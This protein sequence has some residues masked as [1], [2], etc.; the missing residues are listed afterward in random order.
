M[1]RLIGVVA[2]LVGA[3]A[4]VLGVGLAIVFGPDDRV[5]S[6]PHPLRS[7][8]VAVVTGPSTI[9]YYGL[10]VRVG[11]RAARPGT[12]IFLALAHS[13]DV[14]DY[15][16]R[17]SYTRIDSVRLPWKVSTSQ[18]HGSRAPEAPP[19][20]LDIWLDR[21]SGQPTA[22]ITMPLPDAAVALVVMNADGSTDVNVTAELDVDEP[23]MFVGG[24]AAA[25]AGLGV[26]VA[27]WLVY[28]TARTG[29]DGRPS[30][31]QPRTPQVGNR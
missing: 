31:Y 17:S 21:Q 27:G 29:G 25:L 2:V 19:T 3:V 11:V 22:S 28:R 13:V 15:L 1:R 14:A 23:G 20:D 10:T 6:G 8:G 26:G 30:G 5:S 7:D 24:L 4:V 18:V 12:R 9:R 16:R